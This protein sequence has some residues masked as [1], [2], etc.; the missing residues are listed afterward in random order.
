MASTKQD[1]LQGQITL[2]STDVGYSSERHVGY[3]REGLILLRCTDSEGTS[4]AI[5]LVLQ[6]K[7]RDGIWYNME[8][9]ATDV[10]LTVTPLAE[11]YEIGNF[12]ETIRVSY[13]LTGSNPEATISLGL[14]HKT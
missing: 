6:T 3:S 4:P 9:I 10:D 2:T 13:Q 7:G 11:A 8:D 5:S 1:T 14:V 12:G